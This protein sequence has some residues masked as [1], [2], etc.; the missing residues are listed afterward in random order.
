MREW[1]ESEQEIQAR[2]ILIPIYG[3]S[4]GLVCTDLIQVLVGRESYPL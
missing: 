2:D 1:D 3:S 4:L